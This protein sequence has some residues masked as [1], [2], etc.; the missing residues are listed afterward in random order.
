MTVAAASLRRRATVAS[1]ALGAILCL[2]FTA[3]SIGL[4]EKY[5]EVLV[6]EMLRS[7][8]QHYDQR[9]AIDPATPLP[10][11]ER[12]NGYLRPRGGVGDVPAVYADLAP[13]L[14]ES[15]NEDVDGIHVGVFDIVAGRLFLVAD[16][17]DVE[18]L[19]GPVHRFVAATLVLGTALA[20]W[21]GWLLAGG[22]L[23]PLRALAGAVDALPE[24]P[25]PT[26]LAQ[27]MGT[28]ELGRL[29]AAIDAY[30]QRL[31]DADAGERAFFADASHELRTPLAVVRGAAEVLLDEPAADASM[32]RKLQRL[33]RGLQT[34]SDL[35]EVLLGLARRHE[36]AP[37]AVDARELCTRALADVPVPAGIA[38]AVDIDP[39]LRLPLPERAATLVLR[40][41]VRRLVG[42][43]ADG[44]LR[45]QHAPGRL[46][47]VFTPL[48]ANGAAPVVASG[49]QGL[50]LTLV[51]RLAARLGWRI[52]EAAADG[53]ERRVTLRLPATD[54][55]P[56]AT[57]TIA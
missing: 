46:E 33:D 53:G 22:V 49:D 26:Q 54:A 40:S 14:H 8:A 17:R 11:S 35:L 20:G 29:A 44:A 43:D 41:V 50:G 5:E 15:A 45:V 37:A 9:L 10:R 57:S 12:L 27:S 30:Q 18:R 1:V 3:A 51:G 36:Y 6:E 2:A 32:R 21:L 16:L 39:A 56:S 55:T 38:V 42:A 48:H 52:E 7:E 31:V 4:T 13:G 28:D 19:E 25:Q 23:A 34:L 24:R 47:L